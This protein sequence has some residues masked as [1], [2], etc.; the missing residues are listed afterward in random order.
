MKWVG[1]TR[2]VARFS[3][4][5]T[6]DTDSAD[7]TERV[8]FNHKDAKA[9]KG[10][11]TDKP[12]GATHWVARCSGLTTEDTESTEAV[13]EPQRHEG[14]EERIPMKS[15]GA[16]HWVA[17]RSGLTTEDT[18]S[19]EAVIEP[20]RHEGRFPMKWV[21][22]TRWVAQIRMECRRPLR[23]EKVLAESRLRDRMRLA[24][25]PGSSTFVLH[26]R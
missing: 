12:V 13:I 1:A 10:A 3:G 23:E 4:L 21:G 15:V 8:G 24:V 9:T 18:E 11:F 25:H 6:E 16:T 14:H 2:W 22:A 7:S 19:T 20:Q 17:R 26:S 5:T